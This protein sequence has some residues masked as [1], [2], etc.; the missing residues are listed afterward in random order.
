MAKRRAEVPGAVIAAYIR[1][2]EQAF[3]RERL[4]AYSPPDGDP[5]SASEPFPPDGDPASAS[6]DLVEGAVGEP[7]SGD[8]PSAPQPLRSRLATTPITATR[9]CLV[10]I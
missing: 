3:D 5:E 4:D 9:T 10:F 8:T 2:L 7:A 6:A 1:E